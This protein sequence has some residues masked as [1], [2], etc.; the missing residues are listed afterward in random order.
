V[1]F[2]KEQFFSFVFNDNSS[3]TGRAMSNSDHGCDCSRPGRSGRG[4]SDVD[5][6]LAGCSDSALREHITHL[7]RYARMLVRNRPDAE[8]L[9]QDCLTRMLSRDDRHEPVRDMRRYLLTATR[10]LYIT[11]IKQR[12]RQAPTLTLADAIEELG[13]PPAQNDRLKLRDIQ[14]GLEQLPAGQ[15]DAILLVSLEEMSCQQAADRLSVP[16]GTIQSRVH[17]ARAMLKR[18]IGDE[19]PGT[20]RPRHAKEDM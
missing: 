14:R 19:E 2:S 8:D 5:Q 16:I 3:K 11:Q 10:N 18:L 6:P 13:Y 7:F 15:R 1:I 4:Q 12:I 17:R 9:V 20:A